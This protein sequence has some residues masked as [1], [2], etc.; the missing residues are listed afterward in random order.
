M[1][2][3]N[4]R[5]IMKETEAPEMI[6]ERVRETA[7]MIKEKSALKQ[8]EIVP[9]QKFFRAVPKRNRWSWKKIA[10][11]TAAAVCVIGGT[12]FAA[13][14]LWGI[15]FEQKDQYA[16]TVTLE[17]DGSGQSEDAF[18]VPEEVPEVSLEL[19]YL[20]EGMTKGDKGDNYYL[21]A[22]GNSG[23]IIGDPVLADS[24]DALQ[25]YNVIGS[26]TIDV[27]G[28][29]ALYMES[30]EGIDENSIQ[31]NLYILYPE[32]YRI[33]NVW[34]WGNF[35]EDELF[36][37][38]EGLELT[39][40][41]NQ[42][43]AS[44]LT[45]WSECV[46]NLNSV[47]DTAVV[48]ECRQEATREE[49]GDFHTIGEIFDVYSGA[50]TFGEIG[51]CVSDVKISEN[52]NDLTWGLYPDNWNE[53]ADDSGRIGKIT[54]KAIKTGD[55]IESMTRVVSSEEVQGKLVIVTV[56]YANQSGHDIENLWFFTSLLGLEETES[57][58]RFLTGATDTY[59]EIK[60]EI[61]G[62]GEIID[63]YDVH[64]GERN[65]NYIPSVKNGETATVHFAWLVGEDD[66][67]NLYLNINA[68]GCY[69]FTDSMFKTGLVDI[70]Q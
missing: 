37:I 30:N 6:T 20:P 70:R 22:D 41:G 58:Y 33:V 21:S 19:N 27:T 48:I 34:G 45:R 42:T 2:D 55:G 29:E 24:A 61:G 10:L 63:A 4:I 49:L 67:D 31:R 52:L 46:A 40:T 50:G 16:G 51:A 68:D 28:H 9:E 57:G 35:D 17:A 69:E 3:N 36:K 13:G 59:D 44:S 26:Q 25:V 11:L 5:K 8:T 54:R 47:R 43:A 62:F 32:E 23:V 60:Y 53:V 14:K 64:G 15:R 7:R 66:L 12:V 18:A 1:S 56:D 39:E 65:N 38:A